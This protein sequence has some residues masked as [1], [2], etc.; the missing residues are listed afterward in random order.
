MF[1]ENVYRPAASTNQSAEGFGTQ[2][3]GSTAEIG[4]A[5]IVSTAAPFDDPARGV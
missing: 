2:N 1:D 5:E 4:Q 3:Q